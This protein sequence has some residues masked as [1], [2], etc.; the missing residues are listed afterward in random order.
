MRSINNI[1]AM[2]AG[3]S[4]SLANTRQ[5]VHLNFLLLIA[6][7]FLDICNSH[8]PEYYLPQIPSR[9][10]TSLEKGYVMAWKTS[11]GVLHRTASSWLVPNGDCQ[12]YPQLCQGFLLVPLLLCLCKWIQQS[13]FMQLQTEDPS[14]AN[15][16]RL[17]TICTQIVKLF[18][19]SAS[20]K[21]R[22]LWKEILLT[23]MNF[24]SGL[25]TFLWKDHR[26][27]YSEAV[28]LPYTHSIRL[29]NTKQLNTYMEN[30]H[31]FP[32]LTQ[33]QVLIQKSVQSQLINSILSK[34]RKHCLK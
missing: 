10:S 22:H 6:Y 32:L 9:P 33:K 18:F 30:N 29:D 15:A 7:A 2:W 21:C 14:S 13:L 31:A 8:I 4:P 5:S 26:I 34:R 12:L 19:S 3:D 28:C 20:A 16:P 17:S 24:I 23:T 27:F 11:L 25:P 1:N